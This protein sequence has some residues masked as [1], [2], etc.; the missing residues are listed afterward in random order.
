VTDAEVGTNRY[1]YSFNDPVNLR[2]PGGNEIVGTGD[3]QAEQ[4]ANA[5]LIA[6]AMMLMDSDLTENE[7]RVLVLQT[8]VIEAE[9]TLMNVAENGRQAMG[10]GMFGLAQSQLQAAQRALGKFKV[11]PNTG[12]APKGRSA[13]IN[14]NTSKKTPIDSSKIKTP[15]ETGSYTITFESGKTYSGKGNLARAKR[16]ANEKSKANNDPVVSIEHKVAKNTREA[17]KAE[18]RRIQAAGGVN[19]GQNF[20][21][22]NSPGKK[23]RAADD[24]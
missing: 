9:I 17:F 19:S 18:D 13:N 8:A 12:N 23:F 1:A 20:N 10:V 16:S 6:I 11:G 14:T 22:I 24:D 4:D 5:D 2:D 7:R 3:T 21:K 15:S